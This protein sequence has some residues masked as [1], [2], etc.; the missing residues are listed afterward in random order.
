MKQINPVKQHIINAEGKILGRLAS[1]IA[2]LLRGKQKPGFLPYIEPKDEVAV[3]NTD[4]IKVSGKKMKQKLY[5]HH[6]GYAKGLRQE[7]L[8][9]LFSR[10]SCQVMRRAVYG[11]LPKNRTRDKII[12]NLKLFKGEIKH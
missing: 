5:I 10:D 3:F 12:K 1:E 9:K 6:T 8:G 4:K 2:V 11:M 7:S